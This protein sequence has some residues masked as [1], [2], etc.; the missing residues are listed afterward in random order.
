MDPNLARQLR[1][2]LIADHALFRGRDPVSLCR[3]AVEG[4]VTAVQL[5]WK[6]ATPREL[7]ALA[8]RLVAE[9][10]VPIFVNDRPDVALAAQC[11]GVHLGA[12]DLPLALARR[13]A[14]P[15]FVLGVSVGNDAEADRVGGAAYAGVGPRRGSETKV[16]AGAA[17]GAAGA[18]RLIARIAPVPAVVI[19]GV[20]PEDIAAIIAAG[21]VGAAVG[22]GI[23]GQ[24]DVRR[25]AAAYREAERGTA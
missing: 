6:G 2:L 17:L 3:A 22:A 1:L 24:E 12:D 19:G 16:D 4:G 15:G 11:A 18:A 13:I 5:R 9:L 10:E 7:V 14:P 8:R 21:G 20:V 23:L 25:A